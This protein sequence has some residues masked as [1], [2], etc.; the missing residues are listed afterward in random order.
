MGSLGVLGWG[1]RGLVAPQGA[2]SLSRALGAGTPGWFLRSLSVLGRGL[3]WGPKG[4]SLGRGLQ[5]GSPGQDL[6][7]SWDTG[8]WGGAPVGGSLAGSSLC[9]TP[10][11]SQS[12]GGQMPS[13]LGQGLGGPL[14][15]AASTSLGGDTGSY[16]VSGT[17][18][19][20]SMDLLSEAGLHFWADACFQHSIGRSYHNLE[21][22]SKRLPCPRG[23]LCLLLCLL[24]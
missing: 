20:P 22:L 11:C 17:R 9:L 1:L 18:Q 24:A 4:G 3:Q 2:G 13:R 14:T 23:S 21:H 8:C 19:G 12:Y 6:R 16:R 10:R 15:L 7:L 5:A